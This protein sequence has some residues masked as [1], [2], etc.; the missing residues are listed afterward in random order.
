MIRNDE[1]YHS[2]ITRRRLLL[3]KSQLLC[4][5]FHFFTCTFHTQ[6]SVFGFRLFEDNCGAW[7]YFDI[8]RY[9]YSS[10]TTYRDV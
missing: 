8:N 6:S 2:Q 1:N 4:D 9:K 10:T 5:Y 7:Y 3:L